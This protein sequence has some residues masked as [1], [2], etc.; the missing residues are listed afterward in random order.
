MQFF[1]YLRQVNFE[2]QTGII[3]S[4]IS[5]NQAKVDESLLGA[6]RGGNKPQLLLF[7]VTSSYLEG[8]V[9]I[10]L[11]SNT[12]RMVSAILATTYGFKIIS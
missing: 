4:N 3:G 5:E 11:S 8:D 9:D 10:Y 12:L 2:R 7:D 1:R 6:G